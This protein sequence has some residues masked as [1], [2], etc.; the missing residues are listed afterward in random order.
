MN[1]LIQ[2]SDEEQFAKGQDAG[3]LQVSYEAG[4]VEAQFIDAIDSAYD[5]FRFLRATTRKDRKQSSEAV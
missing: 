5:F 1:N 2:V 4:D 3:D